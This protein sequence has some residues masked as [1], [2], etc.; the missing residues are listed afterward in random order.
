VAFAVTPAARLLLFPP[1]GGPLTTRQASRDAADRQVASPN[2]AFDAGLRPGPFP[3]R[4]ASLLPSLLAATRTGLTPAGDD[5]LM[6]DQLL[7]QH[8]QLWARGGST[9]GAWAARRGRLV[10]FPPAATSNRACGSPA[11]GSPTFF[12]A[13]IRLSPSPRPMRARSDDDSVEIDQPE[14]VRGLEGQDR[15]AVAAATLVALGHMRRHAAGRV[16]AD[17]A[18]VVG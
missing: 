16:V 11:H 15:P 17:R 13:G 14:A 1:A 12:T 2:G 18:E 9:G 10:W 7:K 8:L 3:D 5:E 4:T 6:L